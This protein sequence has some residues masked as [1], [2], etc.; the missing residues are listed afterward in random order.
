[1]STDVVRHPLVQRIVNAYDK[2]GKTDK[3]RGDE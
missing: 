3:R 2:H 1:D